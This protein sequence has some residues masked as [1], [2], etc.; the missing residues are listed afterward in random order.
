M[1]ADNGIY[2]LQTKDGFRVMCTQAIDNIYWQAD[3]TGFNLRELYKFFHHAK[4][5]KFKEAALKEACTQY[6]EIINEYGICPIDASSVEFPLECPPCCNNPKPLV[7][8]V[9]V[10]GEPLAAV[11]LYKLP[12]IGCKPAAFTKFANSIFPTIAGN[13]APATNALTV[14]S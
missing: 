13:D 5:F 4:L 9:P 1:S 7:P 12:P 3:E 14:P 8:G 11:S 6:E 10:V 2:I